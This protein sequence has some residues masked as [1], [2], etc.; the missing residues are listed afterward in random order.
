MGIYL[1]PNNAL[2]QQGLRSEIYVD[3][4]LLLAKLN[5]L[6]GTENKYLCVSRPRRFGKTMA[7]A[8][9]A[10]YYSKGCNSRKLFSSL[11]IACDKSFD[12]HLNKFNVIQIDINGFYRSYDDKKMLVKNITAAVTKEIIHAF[13]EAEIEEK[14]TLATAILKAYA[15]TGETFIIIIDE[16]DVLV[17]EK[18]PHSIF[19]DYIEFLNSLFKNST[20]KPAISLAYLTGILPIVRDRIQSK[21]NEFDEY[22]MLNARQ[23]SEFAGFTEDEAKAL[24]DEY[25]MDFSECKRWYDGYKMTNRDANISIYSP[26][27]VVSAMQNGEFGNYWTQ[28]GSYEALKLYILM[29][30]DGIKQDIITMVGGGKVSVNVLKYLNTMTNFSS[31]DDVFTYLIHL[32]YLAYDRNLKK[33]YI[34]N[35]E[36]RSQWLISIEDSPKY[37]EIIEMV[38]DSKHLLEKTLELDENYIASS[39][40]KAHIRTTNPLTYNNEASFQSAIV[41]EL[42]KNRSAETAIQQ[43][44]ERKYDDLLGHYR[45]EMLLVGVNYDEKTKKHECKIE[46]LNVKETAE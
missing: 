23:L 9:I 13:P 2:L 15:A 37:T 39:L 16:Y 8:M 31:K 40:D 28:T 4:S 30:F 22:S 46:K 38:N 36:I 18:V 45:G 21:L 43:I 14:D 35:N 41:I 34:P 26:K 1:N 12:E 42:K 25:S 24:C 19:K 6:I 20:L 5:A 3:K 33:C 11:K 29:D 32:G 7:S 10:A 27:S 17:R 44:K